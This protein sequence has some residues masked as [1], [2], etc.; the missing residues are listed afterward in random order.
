MTTEQG[1]D[2]TLYRVVV[3]GEG[4]YSIWPLERESPAGW[5]G[6][7]KTG[8]RQECLDY[9]AEAWTDMRPASLIRH[10]ESA[11]N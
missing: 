3:N 10:M 4:Q 5:S 2:E 1:T 6:D 11:G 8:T 9:I 7:G